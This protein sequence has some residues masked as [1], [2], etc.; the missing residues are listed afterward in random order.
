MYPY[1]DW[2]DFINTFMPTDHQVDENQI[3]INSVPKFFEQLG[4]LIS[5]TSNRTLANYMLW[6]VVHSVAEGLPNNFRTIQWDTSE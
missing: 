5:A 4:P 6:R 3:L 2:L 1:L